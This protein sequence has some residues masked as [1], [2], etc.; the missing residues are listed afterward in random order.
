ME[1]SFWHDKW[2]KNQIGFH[3]SET[4]PL[5][6]KHFSRLNLKEGSRIFLPLCGKTRDVAWLLSEGYQVVGVE[7][8]EIAI[9]Q[10]FQ[11]LGVTPEISKSGSLI[12]YQAANIDLF[13]GDFFEIS[14][15]ILGHVDAVYDRAAL[16]ALPPETRAQYTSHLIKITENA[17]Q[18]LICIEYDQS[19][20]N[21]P[22]FSLVPSE[23][24]QHYT[25]HYDLRLLESSKIDGGLKGKIE[26]SQATWLLQTST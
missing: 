5:L 8:S 3:E 19:E 24:E 12:H 14:P 7:L 16:I 17:P 22:P 23:I 26:A 20:M 9:E 21:G 15:L 2:E 18:L 13:V 10:L 6:L 25:A 1:A 4:N 11:E